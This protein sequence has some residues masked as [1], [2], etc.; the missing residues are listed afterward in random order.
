MET[1]RFISKIVVEALK[2][3]LISHL[4]ADL[5]F[6]ERE[7]TYI[8]F[9]IKEAHIHYH[10]GLFTEEDVVGAIQYGLYRAYEKLKQAEAEGK[11]RT[12]KEI[13]RYLRVTIRNAVIDIYRTMV[14]DMDSDTMR[15]EEYRTSSEDAHKEPPYAVPEVR[16]PGVARL[17]GIISTLTNAN[18]HEVERQLMQSF[19]A[20][21]VSRAGKETVAMGL[22]TLAVT[23]TSARLVQLGTTRKEAEETQQSK[24][25]SETGII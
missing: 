18:V 6:S 10:E 7:A 17:L 25:R 20:R 12:P 15:L 4:L 2:D 13:K 24:T 22:L 23:D 16:Q 8:L 9:G 21:K 5:G 14:T 11:K 1:D 19:G 3:P